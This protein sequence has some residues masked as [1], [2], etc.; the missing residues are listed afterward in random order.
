[1]PDLHGHPLHRGVRRLELRRD[2]E[3]LVAKIVAAALL[4][5]V[6]K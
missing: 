2:G 5:E 4:H 1:M 3:R 6:A